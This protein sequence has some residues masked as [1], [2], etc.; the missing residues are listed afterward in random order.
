VNRLGRMDAVIHSA[1]VYAGTQVM[2]VNVVAPYLL[3]ALVHPRA[4]RHQ[5]L[6]DRPRRGNVLEN[7]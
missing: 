6:D 2:P 7:R 5:R 1:G 3:T 4:G